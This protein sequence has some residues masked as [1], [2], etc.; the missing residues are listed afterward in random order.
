MSETL[1]EPRKAQATRI[2]NAER[3]AR[4]RDRLIQATIDCLYRYGYHATSTNVVI[5]HAGLSRGAL[6]HQFATKADLMIAVIDHIRRRRGEVHTQGLNGVDDPHQRLDRLV[7]I[8]WAEMTHPTGIAR[9][10]IM[11]GSRADPEFADRSSEIT[12][13]L[14]RRHKER[15]WGLAQRLGFKDRKIVDE[16][17]QLY[18][19]ALRGLAIDAI[20]KGASRDIEGA[21]ALL[22]RYHRL[23]VADVLEKQ[24]VSTPQKAV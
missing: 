23:L 7:D 2:P 21:V 20:Q 14:E 24:Q 16:L 10:E 8:L 11:L 1:A 13:D 18:A 4:T 17:T 15:M 19:A 12:L 5:A 22:K 6:L 9:I 3:S